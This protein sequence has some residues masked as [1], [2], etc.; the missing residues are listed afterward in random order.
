MRACEAMTLDGRP[1]EMPPLEDEDRCF[2][3][4]PT[5][6]RERAE[7]IRVLLAAETRATLQRSPSEQLH[8]LVACCLRAVYLPFGNFTVN[9][10]IFLWSHRHP[11]RC[12]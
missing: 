12:S 3:H 5:T 6:A 7:A 4:S 9:L 2:Q 11:M 10:R 1:C 8:T